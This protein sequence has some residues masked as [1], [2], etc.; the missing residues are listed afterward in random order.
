MEQENAFLSYV[1]RHVWNPELDSK[2]TAKELA[3]KF[4][5]CTTER[6]AEELLTKVRKSIKK[7]KNAKTPYGLDPIEQI[8]WSDYH[9]KPIPFDAIF[10]NRSLVGRSLIGRHKRR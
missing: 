6:M 10:G 8:A 3:D 1:A 9:K 7:T 4:P 5:E 2:L